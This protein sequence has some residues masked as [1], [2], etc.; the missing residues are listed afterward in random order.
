[1][2]LFLVGGTMKRYWKKSACPYDC[3]DAC[4]LLVETDGEKIYRVKG[5]DDHPVTKGFICRKMIHYA[6]TV[7][8]KARIL[9]PL[10]R[11][12]KKGSGEFKRISWDTAIEIIG[13]RWKDLIKNYGAESILQYSYAGTEH[14]IS[15]GCGEVFFDC[16]GASRLARTICAKAKTE[17]FLQMYGQTPGIFINDIKNSDYIVLW[18]SNIEATWIHGTKEIAQARKNG[19]KVVLIETYKS[20]AAK[21]ADDV[22]LL[23][24]GSDGAFALAVAHVLAVEGLLDVDFMKEYTV[25]YEKFVDSLTMYTPEWA[26]AITGVPAQTIVEFAN[27]YGT[28]KVPLIVM[29]SGMSR[30]TNGTMNV[31]CIIA[32]P[33]LV[34][35]FK[36]KGGG[37]WGHI[38]CSKAFDIDAVYDKYRTSYPANPTRVFNMNQLGNVLAI[39]DNP[40]RSLY[41]YNSNPVCIA[42]DQSKIIEGLEREGLFTVV[43]ERFMTDTARYADIILPADTSVEHWDLVSPYGALCVQYTLPVIRAPGE[44][45]SNW[46]TFCLL[47]GAMGLDDSLWK[48]SNEQIQKEILSVDNMWRSHWSENEKQRFME[49][50]ACVLPLPD[51]VDFQTPSHKIML[52]NEDIEHPLPKY[53]PSHSM[54]LVA[55]GSDCLALVVAPATHTLNS[56]FNEQEYLVNKRGLM[57]LK[58]S[59]DDAAKRDIVHGD[60]IDVFNDLAHVHFYAHVSE[61]VPSGTAIA[62]GVYTCEQSLNGLTVNALLS[63]TLTDGGAAATLCDNAVRIRKI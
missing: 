49:G 32:L 40:V 6:D 61:D 35:A 15:S 28:A 20:G 56:T 54:K 41:V 58:M 3:P 4:G 45:K 33:A 31:R 21:Y 14:L 13:D 30:H 34:G 29:G 59:V 12:G 51:S 52:Y 1:M 17:A 10:I 57:S 37:Y 46:D 23:R 44:C 8:N 53:M 19:S 16:L 25:G 50:K 55:D 43:H 18:G 36:N 27:A 38:G 2:P 9:Y 42:P 48:M 24:P 62:E 39:K 47:A 63:Q 60:M 7:H 22:I 5:D 26:S 11:T